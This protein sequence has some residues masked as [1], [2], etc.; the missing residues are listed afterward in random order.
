MSI[1]E[2]VIGELESLPQAVVQIV[3]KAIVEQP[4][5]G[6]DEIGLVQ[7]WTDEPVPYGHAV[8]YLVAPPSAVSGHIDRKATKSKRSK[9]L[10]CKAISLRFPD[11]QCSA[12]GH[13]VLSADF[14]PALLG[15][16]AADGVQVLSAIA[17][18]AV[19]GTI[20][21]TGTRVLSGKVNVAMPSGLLEA[22]ISVNKDLAQS[23]EIQDRALL[24]Y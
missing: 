14:V 20:R 7:F 24:S 11:P 17:I 2:L 15:S 6:S 22:K 16:V 23:L 3:A 10:R 4:E 1:G 13:C 9:K 8:G 18:C 21:A 5:A 12:F 19:V